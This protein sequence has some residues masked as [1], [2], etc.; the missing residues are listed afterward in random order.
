[1][2][3]Q[4]IILHFLGLFS[5]CL[6]TAQSPCGFDELYAN[7]QKNT[8]SLFSQHQSFIQNAIND[9]SASFRDDE[10]I[11][12]PLV[13]HVVWKNPEEN[14]S[15]ERIANQIAIL[16]ED[17]RGLNEDINQVRPIF[18]GLAGDARIEFQLERTIR[19]H[20]DSVFALTT[21]WETRSVQYPEEIK[22]AEHGGSQAWD[23]Q[24]YLNIWV[25]AIAD[26]LVFGYAYPP[27][28]IANWKA[29]SAAPKTGYDGVVINY[30][31]FGASPPPFT[32]QS[33][34]T[35]QLSGRTLVHEIGHYLGL[36]HTWGNLELDQNGCAV[37]DGIDDTPTASIASFFDCNHTQNSCIES[38]G[39]LPDLIENFMDYSA[40]DCRVSFT[41]QQ[42]EVMRAVL[43]NQRK[44]LRLLEQEERF[45]EEIILY[46]NPSPGNV[47]VYLRKEIK[48][49]YVL[50]IRTID[51][52]VIPIDYN[53][54]EAFPG[55]SFAFDM[56]H[57]ADGIYFLELETDQWKFVKKVVLIK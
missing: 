57:L 47:R 40:D 10:V 18:A 5:A 13:V 46:P 20:T 8:P 1:M 7:L 48:T 32:A 2:R 15:D 17:F 56:S 44:D 29:G 3:K 34:A 52:E 54:N 33:G 39:D 51:R 21:D 31:A 9:H 26:D 6:V 49:D 19:V 37:D 42:I 27:A 38:P 30:K 35:I 55:T 36:L 28:G 4:H 14:I 45:A 24:Y 53:Q 22:D 41:P 12:I 16:N 50:R 25:A 23:P 43:R 11:V